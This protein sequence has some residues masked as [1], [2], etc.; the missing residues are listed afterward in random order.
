MRYELTIVIYNFVVYVMSLRANQMLY[1]F[2]EDLELE[3]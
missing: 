2:S 1:N 3:K